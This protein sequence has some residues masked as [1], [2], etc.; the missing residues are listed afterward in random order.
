MRRSLRGPAAAAALGAALL[1]SAAA[2]RPASVDPG[3]PASIRHGGH[4]LDLHLASRFRTEMWKANVETERDWFTAF[5]TRLGVRYTWR[6]H[7]RGFAE[8]QDVRIHGLDRDTSGAA[9]LYRTHSGADSKVAS[10]RVRQLWLE[11]RPLPELGLRAGRQDILLGTQVLYPEA[12]WTYLK[13]AR[14]SQRLVGTV[15][16]THVERSNDGV[17]LAW[18]SEEHHLFGFA[19]RPTTGVFDVDSAYSSQEDI[20]YAGF[21][22]TAKRSAWIEDTELRLFGIWY[23][24]ERDPEDGGLLRVSPDDEVDIWTVGLSTLTVRPI[25][26]GRADLLL[27]AAFQTGDFYELDHRAFAVLL[28]AGYHLHEAPAS[29]WL[30]A[31]VNLASGDR[32]PRDGDHGTFFNLLP[33][34]HLYYGYAD[35]LALSNLIDPFV[36]LRL[37]PLPRLGLDLYVH[38]FLLYDEDDG[39]RF[40]T[41]AFNKDVFG[42]GIQPSLGQKSVGTEIDAVVRYQ[43]HEHVQLQAGYSFIEGHAVLNDRPDDDVRFAF[44]QILAK[45]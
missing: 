6:E 25:G 28:E 37:A 45:Y 40:G 14:I 18:D 3:P 39:R 13:K 36:Q 4:G 23:R 32:D 16:W 35:Q 12:D 31:G 8:L 15:G 38:H 27:W 10:D 20:R 44:F 5:R 17:T 30:R 33:T 1:L 42:Y 11:L 43:A 34:N 26:P 7:V 24:D 41:G 19:A 21:S 22:W 2:A 9:A 29:P